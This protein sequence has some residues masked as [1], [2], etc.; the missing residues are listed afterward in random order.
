MYFCGSA[1]ILSAGIAALSHRNGADQPGS[2]AYGIGIR[3]GQLHGKTGRVGD[4]VTL[5]RGGWRTD[6]HLVDD[7]IFSAVNVSVY[8]IRI[9]YFLGV[10]PDR[11]CADSL[12][13]MCTAAGAAR[14]AGVVDR[15]ESAAG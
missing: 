10:Q 2:F 5:R 7:R 12:L 4:G 3:N 13:Q 14:F 15:A 11:Q 8:N 9:G 6:L 1:G